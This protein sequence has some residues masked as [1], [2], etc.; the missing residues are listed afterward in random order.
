MVHPILTDC[1][2]S[3]CGDGYVLDQ[4]PSMIGPGADGPGSVP[5]S[6]GTPECNQRLR[7]INHPR[8]RIC[9]GV[10]VVWALAPMVANEN[11]LVLVPAD[12]SLRLKS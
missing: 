7:Y 1:L 12:W 9:H 10:R 4:A 5:L 8:S 3:I 2:N 6:A 11:G